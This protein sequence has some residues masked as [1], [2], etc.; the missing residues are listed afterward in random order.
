MNNDQQPQEGAEEEASTEE[1]GEGEG[2]DA[3]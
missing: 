1:T 3:E 2:G